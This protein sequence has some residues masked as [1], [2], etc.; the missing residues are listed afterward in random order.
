MGVS[1]PFSPDTTF[2][3]SLSWAG[4]TKLRV[5]EIAPT[6]EAAANSAH[7]VENL[8]GFVRTVEATAATDPSHEQVRAEVRTMLDSAKLSQHKDRAIFTAT[9]PPDL[10]RRMMDAPVAMQTAPGQKKQAAAPQP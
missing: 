6:P 2:V 9:I 4:K 3:A 1:L 10:V 5:E 8:L 7:A